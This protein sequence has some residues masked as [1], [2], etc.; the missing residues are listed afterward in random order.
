MGDMFNMPKAQSQKA[1]D[2]INKQVLEGKPLNLSLVFNKYVNKFVTGYNDKNQNWKSGKQS[3]IKRQI[4]LLSRERVEV[5][6]QIQ[7]I[8]KNKKNKILN[9]NHVVECLKQCDINGAISKLKK[10]N[11]ELNKKLNEIN[12]GISLKII[13]NNICQSFYQRIEAILEDLSN[14]K[15]VIEKKELKLN[16]RLVI[17]LGATSVYETS[18]LFHR[19][20]SIPYI[21]GSAVKGVTR[22]WAILKFA[23][24]AENTRISPQDVDKALSSGNNLELS[25]ENIS[26]TDLIEIF[27]TQDKKGK[28]IFFDALP[29]IDKKD[30]NNNN[31]NL[32]VLDV[33]NVHYKPYYDEKDEPGD[34]HNPIPVFFLAVEKGT[35][36]RFVLASKKEELVEKAEKLLE[37]SLENIGIGA[38]TS[39]GYGYLEV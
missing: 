31:K 18:L 17:N 23:K 19:N 30:L 2:L 21:P 6:K 33:M 28:V 22:H 5:L 24:N 37:E 15:Y 27:G 12:L 29:I 38:K 3:E 25:V 4:Y 7:E 13:D 35:K 36:F 20:Y 14:M 34:W 9:L 1:Y 10:L 26:F 39:A 8:I 11:N 32:I 16:W